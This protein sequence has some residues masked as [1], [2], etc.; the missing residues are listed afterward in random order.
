MKVVVGIGNPGSRYQKTRHNLGFEVAD[1][2]AAQAGIAFDRRRF[3]AA[4]GAYH[5]LVE[6]TPEHARDGDVLL[7]VGA[8][9]VEELRLAALNDDLLF[10]GRR[11]RLSRGRAA[12]SGRT[13]R[14][15][16][17]RAPLLV[18]TAS[19]HH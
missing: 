4:V 11:L 1:R 14:L 19:H 10:R 18:I 3:D 8:V 7:E 5:Q 2:V 16:R 9:G 15:R 13:G 6:A 12:G 17:C